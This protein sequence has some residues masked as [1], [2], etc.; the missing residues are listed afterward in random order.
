MPRPP[1]RPSLLRALVLALVSLLV[2]SSL[3]ACSSAVKEASS[4]SEDSGPTDGGTLRIGSTNDIVPASIFTNSSDAANTLIGA[5][6]DSLI[7]YPQDSLDPQPRLATS[8]EVAKDGLS[9]TLQLRDDVTFH[10]GREFTSKDV[11][12]SIKTWADPTWTV[13]LQR[14]AA[15]VTGFDTSDPH[16]ITLSFDHPLSNIFDLLDMLPIIDSES[17][18]QLK[19]GKAYVGTG[20]FVFTSWTPSSKLEF[21]RNDDYWGDEPHLDGIEVDIVSDPQAQVSQLR[22]GQLD[23]I[24]GASNRDLETLGKDDSYTVTPF[25]GSVQQIYVGADLANPDLQDVKLRQAIAY[26]LDRQRIV[27]DVFRGQGTPIN[28]PWPDYSPA[29]DAKAN[30]TYAYD[31]DKAKELVS[32]LGSHPTIPLAYSAGNANYEAVAQIVQSDLEAV[33]IKTELQPVENSQFIKQL[34][35]GTFGGLWILQHGYAHYTP[36]TLAVS[37]YPFNADKNASHFVDKQYK[38][39][40]DAAWE[41]VDGSDSGAVEIYQRLNKDLL[42]NLFL[43]EIALLHFTVASSDQVHDLGMSKRGELDLDAAYLSK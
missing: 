30:E 19:E 2:V 18:D 6:Y 20:P 32:Q 24:T 3:A 35:G 28:L 5:V 40:A 11:E 43:I 36:S 42:D 39:D 10:S 26:A 21:T 29:Y 8:W 34:I 17:F 14:T 38:E 22:S 23:L 15:A 16:A 33:G 4:G 31:P 7:D 12:F 9:I 41:R 27:D 13:Q 1:A 25:D 37:A